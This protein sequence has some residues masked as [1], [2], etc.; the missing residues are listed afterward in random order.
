MLSHG[1]V[2][3]I[4]NVFWD[5]IRNE[6]HKDEIRNQNVGQRLVSV[7]VRKEIGICCKK[8]ECFIQAL[9]IVVHYHINFISTRI[10]NVSLYV[11]MCSNVLW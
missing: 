3:E 7:L 4:L 9:A 10:L 11:S 2:N 8:F 1:D 5:K 6:M